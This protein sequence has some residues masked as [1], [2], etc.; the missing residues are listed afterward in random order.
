[1]TARP[2]F[3]K[4]CLHVQFTF[5]L[6]WWPLSLT[7]LQGILPST[8]Y[9]DIISCY[10]GN[11]IHP[12]KQSWG[13]GG[14]WLRILLMFYIWNTSPD[15]SWLRN[16]QQRISRRATGHA[17]NSA[18]HQ[19][20]DKCASC[21][22]Q[23]PPWHTLLR[24]PKHLFWYYAHVLINPEHSVLHDKVRIAPSLS[25]PKSVSMLQRYDHSKF[26]RLLAVL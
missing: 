14:C 3:Q 9:S 17:F 25:A 1:M 11:V 13:E 20:K 26:M 16:T 22:T 6:L 21:P 24:L 8:M 12:N 10:Q 2:F 4:V 7:N 18:Q 23:P 5:R 15:L 19:L